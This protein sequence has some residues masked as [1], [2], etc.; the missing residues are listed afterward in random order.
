LRGGFGDVRVAV[1]FEG[2]EALEFAEGVAVVALGGIDHALEAGEGAV[3]VAEGVAE[4]GFLAE[5]VGGVH[6][7]DEDL[8]FGG[9][10]AAEG[11]RGA[12]E[13]ID[14]VALLGDSG[15]EALE[16]LAAKGVEM[17]G[18]FTG[19]D[20][21]LGVDA[22]FQGIH[23]GTGFARSGAWSRGTVGMG[24]IGAGCFHKQNEKGR[25]GGRTSLLGFHLTT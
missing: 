24:A 7:V 22:G 4:R 20:E 12:D 2:L 1:V 15:A 14:E 21:G 11:P 10:E 6:M 9:G 13:D 5:F 17:A 8:G 25:P 18:V 23:G 16:V 3:G 19:N